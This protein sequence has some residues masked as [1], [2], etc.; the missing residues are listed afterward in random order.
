[1]SF[2]DAIARVVDWHRRRQ[3]YLKTCQELDA[4][5]D[6]ELTDLGISRWDIRAIARSGVK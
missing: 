2:T 5:T 3:S 4:Y 6:R 1:M